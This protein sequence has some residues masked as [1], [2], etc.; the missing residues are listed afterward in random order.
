MLCRKYWEQPNHH[1]KANRNLSLKSLEDEVIIAWNGPKIQHADKLIKET[2][3]KMYGPG[4]WHFIRASAAARL[5]F[6]PVSA[7]VDSLQNADS[8]FI[9]DF[10]W[11]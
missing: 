9:L 1:N 7:A 6:H 10:I 4:N 11:I 3:D 5:K 8:S 2:I